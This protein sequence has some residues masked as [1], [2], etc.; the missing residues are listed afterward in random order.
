MLALPAV[1]TSHRFIRDLINSVGRISWLT[2]CYWE[3]GVLDCVCPSEEIGGRHFEYQKDRCYDG[4]KGS[5]NI[6]LWV[7]FL[8]NLLILL[9]LLLLL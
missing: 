7:A 3:Q 4:L 8:V 6:N 2:F 1:V 5:K 9:L